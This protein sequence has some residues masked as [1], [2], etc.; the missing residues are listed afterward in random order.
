MK[1]SILIAAIAACALSAPI[2]SAQDKAA[3][4]KPAMGRDMGQQMSQM[5][6]SYTHLT[7]PTSDL[8]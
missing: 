4:D 1:T 5:P 3:T 6:V 2:A 8:V 7:L